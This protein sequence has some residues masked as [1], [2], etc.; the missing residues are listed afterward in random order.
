MSPP[1]TG[2]S[3]IG[4]ERRISLFDPIAVVGADCS[5]GQF[6]L[7]AVFRRSLRERPLSGNALN[8]ANLAICALLSFEVVAAV[9][10]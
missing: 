1:L 10:D 4:K 7:V 8:Y 9:V 3:R 6:G 5:I 2:L